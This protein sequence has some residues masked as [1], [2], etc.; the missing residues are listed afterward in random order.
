MVYK[1]SERLVVSP[2]Q[3]CICTVIKLHGV[4][5]ARALQQ[6]GV[7]QAL[8]LR[9]PRLALFYSRSFEMSVKYC[10]DVCVCVCVCV[11]Q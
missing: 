1:M 8:D 11:I 4:T 6:R 10:K 2:L 5:N 7:E 9:I 3:C